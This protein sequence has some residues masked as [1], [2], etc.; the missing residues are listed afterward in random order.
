M[1]ERELGRPLGRWE[2]T[3]KVDWIHL[4]QDRAQCRAL[5]NTVMD[6]RVA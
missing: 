4:A 5:A 2:A 6:F 3:I 1:K